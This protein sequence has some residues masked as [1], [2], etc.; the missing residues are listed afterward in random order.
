M[1]IENSVSKSK[2]FRSIKEYCQMCNDD[3]QNCTGKFEDSPDCELWDVRDFRY[4]V[5]DPIDIPSKR[6]LR[7]AVRGVC[8]YCRSTYFAKIVSCASTTCP[9][10]VLEIVSPAFT[11]G[12]R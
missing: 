11:G 12:Q 3:Y 7:D 2:L 4:D 1:R 5:S 8:E 10:K 6:R 9:F